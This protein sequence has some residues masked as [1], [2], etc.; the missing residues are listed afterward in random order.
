MH[1][2]PLILCG[3]GLRPGWDRGK[4]GPRRFPRTPNASRR[5]G[6]EAG[7]IPAPGQPLCRSSSFRS[8]A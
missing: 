2:W 6:A 7:L 3:A 1:A 8:A 5:D 4:C